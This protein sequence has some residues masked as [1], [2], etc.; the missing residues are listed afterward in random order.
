MLWCRI[1]EA[2]GTSTTSC[3]SAKA[4][5]GASASQ[6]PYVG[7]WRQEHYVTCGSDGGRTRSDIE[8]D[9]PPLGRPGRSCSPG[10]PGLNKRF[11]GTSPLQCRH[12]CGA[13][14]L[15]QC[16]RADPK[17]TNLPLTLLL[18]QVAQHFLQHGLQFR[19]T[20]CGC[21]SDNLNLHNEMGVNDDISEANLARP[22]LGCLPPHS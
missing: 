19:Q 10:S 1:V 4:N 11:G 2:T 12:P 3:W 22:L 13:V 16:P 6:F 14:G 7:S 8:T 5:G 20:M 9:L 17:A 18:A 15:Y 21:R